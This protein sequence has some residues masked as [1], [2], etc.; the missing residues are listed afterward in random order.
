MKMVWL[1]TGS[2]SS[3]TRFDLAMLDVQ[4]ILKWIV[5][6]IVLTVAIVLLG[7]VLNIAG[8]LLKYAIKVLIM[9]LLVAVGVRFFELLRGRR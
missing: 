2:I 8:F 1:R 7:V 4:Q 5:T 3:D 9:L 6:A